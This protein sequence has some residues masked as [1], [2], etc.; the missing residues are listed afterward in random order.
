M[1]HMQSLPHQND[2]NVIRHLQNLVKSAASGDADIKMKEEQIMELGNILAQNKQTEELRKMI[3]QTRPFL[4]SLGKAKAS[5]LVRDLVELCLEIEGQD[6]D[7]KV[8]LVK[9]SIQWATEQSRN[10][11]RQTLQSRLVRLYN[12]LKRYTLALPLAADLIKE[13]KKVEDKEILMEVELE[14]SKAFYNLGNLGR[15]RASLTGA[16]TTANAIYVAPKVQA[17]LDLQAG[18]LH[19]ADEKDFKT[20]FSYFYEAFEAYTTS[21]EKTLAL[22]SLKYMLLCKVMLDSPDEVNAL[23]AG[24]LALKYS[25]SDL[26]AMRAVASAAKKR[27]LADFKAAFGHYPQELQMDPVVKKHFHS[28][29]ERMLEK[30]LCRLIEPYSYVQIDHIAKNIGIDRTLVEKKL[31]QMILDHKFSGVLHQGDGMLIV[32]DVAPLDATYDSALDTI[33]A[34]GEVVDALYHRAAQLR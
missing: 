21:D 27:S 8:E 5:K 2:Q 11:L 14:E 12:D 7:V 17:A 6:G 13:L 34:L 30:D 3:E 18:I 1:D 32:F 31:A 9:E 26:E 29:S 25:G 24:K 20:A 16:R 22:K 33:H 15:A 4:L 23:L 19:A 10:Y 28:L